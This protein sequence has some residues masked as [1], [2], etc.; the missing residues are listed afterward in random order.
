M[1]SVLF[2]ILPESFFQKLE[3]LGPPEQE[4]EQAVGTQ[5]KRLQ[6]YVRGRLEDQAAAFRGIYEQLRTGTAST[7]RNDT[8]TTVVFDRAADRVCRG[9]ALQNACWHR[10]YVSTYNALND[11]LPAMLERGRGEAGD[12]PPHFASR[13]LHL[14][15]FLAEINQELTALLTR[16]QY[17]RRLQ[18]NRAAVCRQYGELSA[19]LGTAAAELAAELTPDQGR[20][21]R[22]KQYLR[23]C[24]LEA[25]GCA[26]Y[27]ERGHLRVEVE[28]PDLAPLETEE[29]QVKLATV[30]G[31]PLHVGTIRHV[32]GGEVMTFTQ[33]ERFV[34]TAG[35]AARRKDGE[36][37]SGDAGTWFKGDNGVL[38]VL[39]CDGMGSGPEAAK[40]STLALRLLEDFLRA[41]VEPEIAL[42]T[43]NGALA[44]RGDMDGGF[45]TIDLLRVDLF[46]GEATVY[47]LGAAPSYVCKDGHVTRITGTTLP[48]GLDSSGAGGPDVS[49]VRLNPGDLLMMVSDGVAD[50]EEDGWLR[51]RMAEFKGEKP[52]ELALTVI[53]ESEQTGGG[54]DDRTVVVLRLDRRGKQ[55]RLAAASACPAGQTV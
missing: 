54:T 7:G 15:A 19:L 4:E 27:D 29:G 38:W 5:G 24:G 44:L 47:K 36:A 21:K 16:R 55:E 39:I 51:T 6:G 35:I 17:A 30:L 48:A 53:G 42:R 37:V 46:S 11:A 3:R 49:R 23:S 20:S 13:C 28:G 43:L 12:F 45:T 50:G 8:D 1:A 52:K 41:G 40:D 18:E 2:L 32:R 34:A 26:Y 31:V 10:D 33:A 22:L 9:C 14:N 25:T